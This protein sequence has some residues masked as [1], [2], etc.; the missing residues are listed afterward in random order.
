MEFEIEVV[1]GDLGGVG[2]RFS[3]WR[4]LC[5]CWLDG[6]AGLDVVLT[7]F[8]VC[9]IRD[10]EEASSSRL[11]FLLFPL[12]VDVLPP[13]DFPLTCRL[14]WSSATRSASPFPNAS[15]RAMQSFNCDAVML[16]TAGDLRRAVHGTTPSP[17]TASRMIRAKQWSRWTG[18]RGCEGSLRRARP[19]SSWL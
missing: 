4:I 13:F 18:Q 1:E 14:C 7:F 5:C 10:G 17:T 12:P 11:P 8:F 19:G 9:F 16:C 15:P 2:G 3:D 6:G